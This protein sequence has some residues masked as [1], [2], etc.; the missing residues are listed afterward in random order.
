[1]VESMIQDEKKHIFLRTLLSGDQFSIFLMSYFNS[2]CLLDTLYWV[3]FVNSYYNCLS[4]DYIFYIFMDVCVFQ[5]PLLLA[6]F[7]ILGILSISVLEKSD[8]HQPRR[9][10][11][12]IGWFVC[13]PQA[14]EYVLQVL[15]FVREVLA[16]KNTEP[17]GTGRG[18]Y[19]PSIGQNLQ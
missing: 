14:V 10:W 13:D 8:M 3:V 16:T 15:A 17:A 12:C 9:R 18:R 7:E 5:W 11:H 1:M 4:L 2:L 6:R 19:R